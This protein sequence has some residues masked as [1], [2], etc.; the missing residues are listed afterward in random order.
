MNGSREAEQGQLLDR[1]FISEE[2]LLNSR[3]YI[4]LYFHIFYC[5]AWKFVTQCEWYSEGWDVY[6]SQARI[7]IQVAFRPLRLTNHVA[8][9]F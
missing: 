9:L 8:T 3:A 2:R 6:Q 5:E 4:S 1:L 7:G